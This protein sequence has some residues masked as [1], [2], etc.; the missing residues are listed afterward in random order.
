[1]SNY[2]A[3]KEWKQEK[4]Q[5]ILEAGFRLFAENG[6]EQVTMT[7]IAEASKVGR[8][9]LFRYFPS[10]TELVIAISTWKWK[11]Y[12]TWHNSLL[13]AEEMEK[14]TGAEQLKIYIVSFLEL[15]RSHK[16]MLR[17]NYNFNS[18]LSY[19][20]GTL[21]QKQPYQKLVDAL[22]LQFHTLYERG[23]HDGTLNVDI[24]EYTMFSSVFHIMLA[25]V[26][27]YAMGLAIVNESDTEKELMMLA[28]MMLSRFTK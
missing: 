28:D 5:H 6:I 7:D 15:Y 14:L 12:I 24:P 17:F 11:E 22:S 16:D 10:K 21:E 4:Y 2:V 23:R 27:R 8:M 1:M 18:F 19:Q 26:T 3:G 9:T 20:K 13:S 25:A